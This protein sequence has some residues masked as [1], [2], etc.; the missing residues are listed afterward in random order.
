VSSKD[1]DSINREEFI[2]GLFKEILSDVYK[3]YENNTDFERFGYLPRK[4]QIE[5]LIGNIKN[6]IVNILSKDKIFFVR[7]YF[8]NAELNIEKFNGYFNGLN[9]LSNLL[10]D[11][12]SKRL[13]VKVIAFRILGKERVKMPLNTS[14]YWGKR[15]LAKSLVKT[16]ETISVKFMDWKLSFFELDEIGYPIQMYLLPMAI[17]TRFIIK[18]YEYKN[19]NNVGLV[20]PIK[21]DKGD[22]VIDAGACYG[23]SALYFAHEVGEKGGVYSFEFISSNLEVMDKNINLNPHLKDRIEIVRSPLWDK[24]GEGLYFI[25]NG[26]GSMVSEREITNEYALVSTISIDDYVEKNGVEKVD[27]IKMDIEGAELNALKGT[28]KT[29]RKYRPKLAISLYHSLSDFITI[30]GFLSSLNLDYEFYLGHYTIHSE[31]T[32]LFAKPKIHF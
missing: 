10:A 2:I 26:P 12:D 3:Y 13:L 32:V 28:I 15:E 19:S 27:F 17:C 24:S 16:N 9:H 4:S 31:E 30:P 21:A 11:M 20:N 6:K 29:L 23:D 7:D 14:G 8:K 25:D 18:S 22:I 5:V 1:N